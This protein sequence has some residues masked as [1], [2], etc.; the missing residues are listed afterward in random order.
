[1]AKN[2]NSKGKRAMRSRGGRKATKRSNKPS[3]AFVRKVQKIIHKDVE[4]KTTVFSSNVTAY[5]QQLSTTGDC[6]RLIPAISN[7]TA[8]N[9]KIGN[10]IRLQ[11]LNLRGVLTFF[12]GQ[13]TSNNTRIGVRMMILKAKRFGDW[14]AAA[15]DFA[16]NYTK[17]LEGVSTGF[18]G[19]LSQFNTP[20][21]HDYFSV[22]M[23][24]RIYMSQSLQSA[25][26]LVYDNRF[27]TKF[28]NLNVP[29]SR[30]N[31]HYDQDNSAT[32]P[33]DYPYFMLLGYTKLDGSAAD[34]PGASYLTFQYTTTAK[35]ED[36]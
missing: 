2:G 22:V 31:I 6:L 5:N 17:L 14:N 3:K 24:K 16:T 23:D 28:V 34:A 35:F 11:S 20:I 8:E 9:Q 25:S 19:E 26:T 30:R 10:V 21:N 1:M 15:T 12:Q 33:V 36:A 7:G 32:E 18:Q 29:Y 4:T 27:T 13:T